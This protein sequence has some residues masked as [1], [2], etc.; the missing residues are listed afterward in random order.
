M[1]SWINFLSVRAA[2]KPRDECGTKP[3]NIKVKISYLYTYGGQTPFSQH[4]GW[5]CSWSCFPRTR[6]TRYSFGCFPAF[7]WRSSDQTLNRSMSLL[8][9][10][11]WV[12]TVLSQYNLWASA[13][14]CWTGLLIGCC[15]IS[16]LAM[17]T[18]FKSSMYQRSS[19][20]SEVN[21][22]TWVY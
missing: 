2:V 21:F 10:T 12:W 15:T 19:I 7:G 17:T 5:V 22:D 4:G 6:Q 3:Y 11:Q 13:L 1:Y 16:L 14:K 9:M 8:S 20:W 18:T